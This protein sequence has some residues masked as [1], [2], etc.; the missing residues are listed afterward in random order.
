MARP[1]LGV[2]TWIAVIVVLAVFEILQLTGVLKVAQIVANFYLFMFA[3]V[4]VSVLA[5]VGAVFLGITLAH[6]LMESK[7]FT[8]F[9]EE[10]LSMKEQ[11]NKM[12]KML[13]SISR[14]K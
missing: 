7:D 8:P 3:L 13:E 12:E 14:E 1:S 6:R 5:I 11:I 10:M 4:I 2:L 9:E